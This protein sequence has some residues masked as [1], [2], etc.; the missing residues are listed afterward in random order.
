MKKL[1]MALCA[2][3]SW[4][5]LE[6]VRQ[7]QIHS[8][9]ELHCTQGVSPATR[10][11]RKIWGVS[12][13]NSRFFRFL[14]YSLFFI[15]CS[16]LTAAP[17]KNGNVGVANP[18]GE[19][20]AKDFSNLIGMDGFD[21]QLL[22]MHFTLY[23]GYVKN[24]NLLIRLINSYVAENQSRDYPYQALKRRFGWEFDGMRLHEVYFG[25]LGGQKPLDVSSG[26]YKIIER[27]FGS[28]EN[29]KKDFF[30]TGMMRG[31]GWSILYFD[32]QA[33]R[34]FNVWIN[35]HDLGHL[36]GGDL[37]LVMDVWEHAYITQYG[38]NRDKY[39]DAFFKN[40]NWQEVAARFQKAV[41]RH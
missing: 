32:P 18:L 33:D 13:A 21:D 17:P 20:S 3:K 31:I 14:V 24:T 11:L 9:K 10:A 34:L 26:L 15:C 37:I 1:F 28:Y 12:L 6:L 36:A 41:I 4:M 8:N 35:E 38:L 25:N 2:H 22:K 16:F 39:I 27:D 19:Y 7:S 5:N 40:I 29:W 30:S 23:N